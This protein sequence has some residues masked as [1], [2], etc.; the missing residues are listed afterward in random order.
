MTVQLP[1][2]CFD[3]VLADPPWSYWGSTTGWGD[4]AKFYNLMSD[5]DLL[6][7]PIGDLVHRRGVLFLWATSPRLDFAVD[8]I[9]RWGLHYR[10]VAFVWVKT[11]KSDPQVPIGAQGVRP[12]IV[13]PTCEYLLA[14]SRTTRG[15]PLP[16]ADEG[17]PQVILDESEPLFAPK[18]GH[19]TKPDEAQARIDRLYPTATK[20]E[21]FARRRR[22]GW[23][24]WGDD[25]SG[26]AA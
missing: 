19:S 12:S 3:V 18:A 26:E 4:A 23:T 24:A 6:A 7:M 15:R 8:C 14:A 5:S 13:K 11:R 25:I 1:S 2:G 17:V 22:P 21:L 10:G 20:L 9:R 16:L